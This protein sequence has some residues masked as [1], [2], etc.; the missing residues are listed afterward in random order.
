MFPMNCTHQQEE[1]ALTDIAVHPINGILTSSSPAFFTQDSREFSW[2]RSSACFFS[3][4]LISVDYSSVRIGEEAYFSDAVGSRMKT[5]LQ[6]LVC[7]Q[8]ELEHPECIYNLLASIPCTC[9]KWQVTSARV[10]DSNACLSPW[11]KQLIQEIKWLCFRFCFTHA[12]YCLLS[13]PT[14]LRGWACPLSG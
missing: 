2:Y 13:C 1:T 10:L 14:I 9:F 7:W 12:L 8:L 11:A 3:I 5:R 4:V 6:L